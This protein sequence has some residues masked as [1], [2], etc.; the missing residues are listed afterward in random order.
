[1]TAPASEPRF[2]FLVDSHL[3]RA[4]A[5]AL[6]ERG[7]DASHL[8]DWLEGAYLHAPDPELLARAA[9]ES[10][11]IITYDSATLPMDAYALLAAGTPCA[12][13]LVVTRAIGQRD[14]GGQM[15]AVMQ[16]LIGRY[17]LADQV[18]YLQP[19]SEP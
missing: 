10:R 2:A 19:A 11:A 12:G 15:R 3:P 14:I 4:L 17:T 9:P 16:A 18:I 7:H 13:V 8:A 5:V 6:A 1:V